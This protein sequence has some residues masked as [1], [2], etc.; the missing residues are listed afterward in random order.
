MDA[1]STLVLIAA[2]P[3]CKCVVHLQPVK[4]LCTILVTPLV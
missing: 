2:R 4:L 3:K 1:M